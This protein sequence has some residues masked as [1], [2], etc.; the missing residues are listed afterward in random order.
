MCVVN[1][2]CWQDTTANLESENG[3]SGELGLSRASSSSLLESSEAVAV[4]DSSTMSPSHSRVSRPE[5]H[6][7][8]LLTLVAGTSSTDQSAAGPVTSLPNSESFTSPSQSNCAT[9][10][11]GHR[12]VADTELSAGLLGASQNGSG[13]IKADIEDQLLM[14]QLE[15]AIMSS[16]LSLE[17]LDRLLV[18]SSSTE[19]ASLRRSSTD[20]QMI[21]QK[22]SAPS[23]KPYFSVLYALCP[24][25]TDNF[26][27]TAN[28]YRLGFFVIAVLKKCILHKVIDS[29]CCMKV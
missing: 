10:P 9:V 3:L 22:H 29:V 4:A 28:D 7:R 20:T 24:S 26:S 25:V 23:G 8:L 19:S 27:H 15:Q 13:D 18:V 2:G 5:T 1:C 17:D 21:G 6:N 16:E 11:V 14:A 12:A